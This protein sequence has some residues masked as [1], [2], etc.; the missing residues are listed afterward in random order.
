LK[1][2]W[3][4]NLTNHKPTDEGIAKI[5]KLRAAGKEYVNAML[6]LCPIS[7]DLSL[8]LTSLEVASFHAIASIARSE[9]DDVKEV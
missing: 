2:E 5:E 6:D 1:K 4:W 3:E 9:T 8:A 7:R